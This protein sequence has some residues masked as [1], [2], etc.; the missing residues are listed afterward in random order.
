ML[1]LVNCGLDNSGISML[2]LVNCGLDNSGKFDDSEKYTLDSTNCE[3][4]LIS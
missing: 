1:D 2:D 3:L 4:G